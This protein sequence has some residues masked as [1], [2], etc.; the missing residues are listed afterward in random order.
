MRFIW[1]KID[2]LRAPPPAERWSLAVDGACGADGAGSGPIAPSG[3]AEAS[4]PSIGRIRT[5]G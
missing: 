3:G 1:S 5:A 4:D 2:L